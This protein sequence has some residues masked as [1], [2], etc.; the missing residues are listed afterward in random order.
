MRRSRLIATYIA[1]FAIVAVVSAVA[2]AKT[3]QKNREKDQDKKRVEVID[4]QTIPFVPRG[5]IYIKDSFGEVRVEGWDRPEVSL[6]VTKSLNTDDTPS[7]RAEKRAKLDRIKVVTK[8]ESDDALVIASTV[9]FK[10]NLHLVYTIKIPRQSDLHIKHG[11][12]EV[13]AT[14]VLSDVEITASIGQ[15]T[16]TVPEGKYDIDARSRLG[17]VQSAFPVSSR[18]PY[19]LAAR[20]R[21]KVEGEARKIY[22]RVGIGEIDILKM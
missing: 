6:T 3:G 17:D 15:I 22:L 13:S 4:T 19:L 9:P 1:A 14:N 16:L 8:R 7:D 5:E 11:I 21:S 12:G 10:R 2:S 18:R 20:A